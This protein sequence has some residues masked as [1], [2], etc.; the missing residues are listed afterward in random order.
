MTREQVM[1]S[2]ALKRKFCKDKNLPISVYENP[3]F[4]QR[5]NTL[6]KVFGCIEWFDIFC[7]GLECFN[8]EQDYFEYYSRIK[9][10]VVNKLQANQKFNEFCQITFPQI[11]RF[12]RKKLYVE[13]NDGVAFISIDMVKANFTSMHYFSDR[14]FDGAETW[15]QF[16]AQ[17]T[18]NKH[19]IGSK[20]IRQ[21]I[22]GLCNPKQQM[23]Y[24][25]F[26]MS[27]IACHITEKIPDLHIYSL[28]ADEIIIRV[29]EPLDI[30]LDDF[31]DIVS[32]CPND[33]GKL[34]KVSMFELDE[35]DDSVGYM[36]LYYKTGKVDFKCVNADV[37]HQV[38][39]HYYDEQ[40]TEDDLVFRYNG[41]LA[42]FLKEI[43]DP[44]DY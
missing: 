30:S 27:Q 8:N 20:H 5:L 9:N 3:Y 23:R 31:K 40:I 37:F 6:D 19:I 18:D 44:W 25:L 2:I 29:D 36:R 17:F 34:V 26:L 33:I 15:E 1:N 14:I 7:E 22:F 39:K 35:I 28:D 10:E 32:S 38:V 43:D 4:L 21:S 11:G 13:D 24:E 41:M 12:N 42:R 16:V